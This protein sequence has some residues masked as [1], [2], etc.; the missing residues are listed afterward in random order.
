MKIK[1]IQEIKQLIPTKYIKR[2]IHNSLFKHLLQPEVTILYGARQVGKS[3]EIYQ[4]IQQ[5]LESN[6][7]TDIFHFNLD[8]P[9]AEGLPLSTFQNPKIFL[10]HIFAHCTKKHT[11]TY[12]FIDEAQRIDGIGIFI[13]YLYDQKHNI[14]FILTG[15][16]SLDIKQKI[17]EPLT[18]RKKE[19]LLHPLFIIEILKYKDIQTENIT[20]YF[21]KLHTVLLEYMLYGGYPEVVTIDDITLKKEKLYEIS[22]SY[23]HRDIKTLFNI[24]DEQELKTISSFLAENIGNL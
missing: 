7:Q 16:A 21:E 23:I 18:G 9:E 15:S 10:N 5:L 11:T 3:C 12:I 2:T 13:K 14:K 19:F 24:D 1:N 6:P 8:N 4:C 20:G 17:K 22:E